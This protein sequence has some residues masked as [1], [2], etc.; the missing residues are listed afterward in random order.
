MP[1]ALAADENGNVLV[2]A[3][4]GSGKTRAIVDRCAAL[5]D[6]GMAPADIL[7]LTFSRRA[8]DELRTRLTGRLG[9]SRAPEVRTFHGFAARLLAGA[10]AGGRS[11]RLLTQPSERALFE[12]IVQETSLDSLRDGV[13]QSPLFRDAAAERVAELR[14]APAEAVSRLASRAT[15]RLADLIRLERTQSSARER[16]GVADYDD[17]VARVAQL[18]ARPDSAVAR[19]L[20]D[21]YRHVLVDEFQDT[22]SLQRALL[23]SFH[24]TIFAV[25]DPDQAIYGFRGAARGAL[26]AACEALR[27]TRRFLARSYRCP[28][29]MCALARAV[30]PGSTLRSGVAHRGE[31]A[32]R[33]AAS[34]HDEAA[35]IGDAIAR[36]IARGTPEREI[37]VLVRRAEPMAE[38]VERDLRERGVAVARRGGNDVLDDPAVDAVRVVLEALAAPSSAASWQRL[39]GHPAFGIDPLALAVALRAEPLHSVDD[40]CDLLDRARLRPRCGVRLIE[41]LRLA[42]EAWRAGEP[43]RAGRAFAAT[44]DVLGFALDADE[45]A[46]RRSAV[47]IGSFFAAFAD[48]VYVREK[49]GLDVSPAASFRAFIACADGWRVA[50][51]AIDDEPGVRVLTVHAAKGLEFDF[52]AIADAVEGAFPQAWL[53][54]ALLSSDDIAHARRCG[55]DLGTLPEEHDAEERSL[56][57]VAVTR[58]KRTLLVTWSETAPDGAPQRPSRFVPLAARVSEAESRSFRAAFRYFETI[59]FVEPQAATAARLPDAVRTSTMETWLSCR[60]KFYYDALLRIGSDERGAAA[61]IGT[62]VHAAIERFHATERDF[63]TVAEGASDGWTQRLARIAERFVI[64]SGEV[65]RNGGV[66]FDTEL[67][68]AAALRVAIRLLARYARHL[69]DAAR[70]RGSFVVESVEEKVRFAYEGVEFAGKIDRVDRRADG[71]LVLLDVKTGKPRD[72]GMADAFVKMRQLVESD[73]LREKPPV[74]GGNPQLSLYRHAKPETA[75]LEYVYLG[76]SGK[77]KKRSDAAHVDRLDVSAQGT[78]LE[79]IDAVLLETFF[80]PWKSDALDYLTPTKIARTCRYC[81]FVRVCPGYLEDDDP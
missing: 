39:L 11:R 34:P 33:R 72:D 32:Y 18:A 68:R 73:T 51:E 3:V 75:A 31:I 81:D 48:V 13:V 2:E 6:K 17:L 44:A 67:E 64:S 19:T 12:R 56:W 46:A 25:G 35:F 57:F 38:L 55:V 77:H 60:R 29:E 63:R 45:A 37:A 70:E 24:A 58:A 74:A 43:I 30:Q 71:S 28:E 52:V 26:D 65:E 69:E 7:V 66:A 50:G 1:E 14:R 47:A 10:G 36:A 49:L 79:A 8:V 21:R 16:L 54:G 53:P 40:V 62:L 15:P 5:I 27:M 9:T 22:D 42:D 59:D 4:P 76:A 23:Q 61:K 20:R 78:A 80:E 41:A